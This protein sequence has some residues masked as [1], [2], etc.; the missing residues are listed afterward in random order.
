[1]QLL[2]HVNLMNVKQPANSNR[3][4]L[5]FIKLCT[6]ELIPTDGLME[7][8]DFPETGAYNINFQ[9]TGYES[10]YAV[11]NLGLVY[12]IIHAQFVVSLLNFVLMAFAGRFRH[13]KTLHVKINRKLYWNG[14]MLLIFET[15]FDLIMVVLVN[16]KVADWSDDQWSIRYTN[17]FSWVCFGILTLGSLLIIIFYHCNI[18]KFEDEEWMDKFGGWLEGLQLD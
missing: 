17:Y 9:D 2:T 13:V 11:S 14:Y 6:F 5:Y 18:D 16:M 12:F 8:F 1:M 15:F 10:V 4:L 7:Y 3:F